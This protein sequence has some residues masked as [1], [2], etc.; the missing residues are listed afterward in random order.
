MRRTRPETRGVM[1][2]CGSLSTR[3]ASAGRHQIRNT[4]HTRSIDGECK[5]TNN[6][7]NPAAQE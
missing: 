7:H 3:K 1:I 4:Q 6:T 5:L 2:R